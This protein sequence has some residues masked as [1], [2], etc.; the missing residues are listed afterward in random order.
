MKKSLSL[1]LAIAMVFG[2]FA[3]AAFAADATI[4]TQAK[5]DALQAKGIF[6]GFEDGSAGLDQTM[7]RAQF[8]K[9]L[10]LTLGLSENE[11]AADIYTDLD[12]AGWAKGFIGGAT[13][14]GLLNGYGNGIYDPSGDVTVEQLAKVFVLGLG[15]DVSDEAV[16]G[17]VSDWAKGYVAA[18]VAAGIIPAADDYTTPEVGS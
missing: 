9:V 17:S 12:G 8:A 16:A 2:I 3:T 11:A 1:I 10:V 15:L 13:E 14:A 5:F 6:Q 7:T 18:A 4:D